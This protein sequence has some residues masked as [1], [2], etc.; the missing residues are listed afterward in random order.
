MSGNRPLV[1]VIRKALVN[2]QRSQASRGVSA[3][4]RNR[5]IETFI[6]HAY[7]FRD[8]YAKNPDEIPPE[9]VILFDEAQ[10]AWDAKQV[11]RFT[12]NSLQQSEP[13]LFLEI[14]SRVRDWSV[15]IAVVGSGQEINRGEAGLGEW[16]NAILQSGTDWIVKASPRT[17]PGNDDI[18]GQPLTSDPNSLSDFSEDPRLHLEMN[19]RS[20]RAEALNQWVDALIDLRVNDARAYFESINDFPLVLTRDLNTA[21][22]W[23]KD[24][25]D[26]D[27]RCGLVANA[28]AKRLRAWGLDTN[29][30]RNDSAWADWFL[31]PHGDVRSSNQL[32]IAAT[33]F[34]CQGLE[35]DWVGMCWGN[36]LTFDDN[37]S[38][39]DTRIFRGT[40]WTKASEDPRK[41]MLNSYRVLLTRAR[42]GMII[43]VPDPDGTDPTLD[44]HAFDAT[45]NLLEKVG[46]QL[47]N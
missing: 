47:I 8:E 44:P 16:G 25:T 26:E 41:F 28:S 39:W 7:Q 36:D 19:V 24:R 34:D 27:H 35:L 14:M 20:P 21:K 30:L 5:R 45:A 12:R 43:W 10:R 31:K 46:L 11:A 38:S 17:L 1:E 2:E 18:P 40:S 37:S 13:E 4:E 32:E 15:I 42:K 3:L 29:S 22:Q 33:N 6:Q 23:L 9:N